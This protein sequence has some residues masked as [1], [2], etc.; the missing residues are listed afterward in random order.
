L[1]AIA[2]VPPPPTVAPRVTIYRPTGAA[3][4]EFLPAFG[5]TFNGGLFVG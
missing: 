1:A 2:V 3:V 5:E 4:R